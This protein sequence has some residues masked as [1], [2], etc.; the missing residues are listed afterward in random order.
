MFVGIGLGLSHGVLGR[1]SL[2]L[3]LVAGLA[4]ISIF[5]L[6]ARV[7][8]I[9]GTGAAAFPTGA[10]FDPD[11][12]ILVVAPAALFDAMLPLLVA[13]AIGAPAFLGWTYWRFREYLTGPA[14][15]RKLGP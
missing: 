14:A 13:A 6:V 8:R 9:G 1:W 2:L 11:D 10:G 7:E 15:V 3:G 4:I 5:A 12:A